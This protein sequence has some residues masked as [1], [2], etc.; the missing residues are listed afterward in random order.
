M[1]RKHKNTK[2]A[3]CISRE[4]VGSVEIETWTTETG[5]REFKVQGMYV[6]S[7]QEALAAAWQVSTLKK[8]A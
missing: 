6:A 8:A 7:Y 5:G 2:P 1:T 4:T 3:K